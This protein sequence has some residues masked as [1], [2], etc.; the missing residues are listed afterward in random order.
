MTTDYTD[1]SDTKDLDRLLIPCHLWLLLC[2]RLF[3]QHL[4]EEDLPLSDSD[5]DEDRALRLIHPCDLPLLAKLGGPDRV[6]RLQFGPPLIEPGVLDLSFFEVGDSALEL[7]PLTVGLV[8][9]GECLGASLFGLFAKLLQPRQLAG[10]PASPFR[11]L[12]GALEQLSRQFETPGDAQRVGHSELTDVKP[13]RRPQCLDIELNCPVLRT[14]V[15]E[16]ICLEVS[17]VRG[18]DGSTADLVELIQDRAAQGGPFRRIGPGPEFVEQNEA[19]VIGGLEDRR[20]P[21]D[22]R[23]ERAERLFQALLVANIREHVRPDRDRASFRR[24][25]VH[26]A[27]SHDREEAGRLQ[28]NCLT[29]GVRPR[30]DQEIE[31]HP[32][33]HVDWYDSSFLCGTVARLLSLVADFM[34]EQVLQQGMP[35]RAQ[36]EP[37]LAVDVRGI[38]VVVA[39]V[40]RLGRDEIDLANDRDRRIDLPPPPAR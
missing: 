14:V 30:D 16:G 5:A 34:P 32:E 11:V 13:V 27:L 10:L 23:T 12:V 2:P 40:L 9:S 3:R 39:A 26:A 36:P 18:H 38:H 1:C 22:V 7:L 37:A 24:R 25:D 6:P 15:R 20:D 17:E 33:P 35:G 19:L 21:R 28:C 4:V 29:P 8:L 31:A